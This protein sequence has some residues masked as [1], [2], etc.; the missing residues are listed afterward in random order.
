LKFIVAIKSYKNFR[1]IICFPWRS[2]TFPNRN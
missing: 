2:A 1:A